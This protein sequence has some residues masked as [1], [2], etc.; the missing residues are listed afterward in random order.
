[1]QSDKTCSL[2]L[3]PDIHTDSLRNPGGVYSLCVGLLVVLRAFNMSLYV[4]FC[5][6]ICVRGGFV[7]ICGDVFFHILVVESHYF[8]AMNIYQVGFMEFK[9]CRESSAGDLFNP[10]PVLSELIPGAC[11]CKLWERM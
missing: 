11:E 8:S 4:C 3:R 2:G 5:L 7:T 9:C 10:H 6:F 1:M